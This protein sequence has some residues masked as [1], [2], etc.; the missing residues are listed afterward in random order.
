[1]PQATELH[2]DNLLL[3]SIPLVDLVLMHN[4]FEWVDVNYREV[5]HTAY[6]PIDHIY[7]LTSGICSVISVGGD[8]ARIEAG[9]IGRE[10][11][12][13]MSVPL[14][15]NEAPFDVLVQSPGRALRL[16]RE[17]FFQMLEPSTYLKKAVMRYIHT[18]MVQTA[19]TALANGRLTIQQRLARWLLMCQDRIEGS[20]LVMTHQTMSVM[21]AVRRSSVTAAI[22]SLE[23]K[24]AIKAM[25]GKIRIINRTILEHHAKGA[26]GVPEREYQRL[27]STKK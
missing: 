27:L 14:T 17:E 4:H 23:S 13:G 1:M 10:G 15:V 16:P 7:F 22:Q 18:F 26:Y 11:F 20:E 8:G 6:Q 3:N 24:Y 12:V 9:I 25:R 2:S 5:L 19:Q 21:L